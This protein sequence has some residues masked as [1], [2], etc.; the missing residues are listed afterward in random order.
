MP[1]TDTPVAAASQPTVPSSSR[2]DPK[3]LWLLAALL[4]L[5]RI[6][7]QVMESRRPIAEVA[8]EAEDVVRWRTPEQG[9]VEA[10][11]LRKPML[12]DF[13]AEWCPPCQRM[14][15]ELF[16]DPRSAQALEQMVV[17]IRVVDREREEGRNP[18]VT[19]SLQRAYRVG[20]FPTL[21]VAWPDREGYE[22]SSGYPGVEATLQWVGQSAMKVRPGLSDPLQH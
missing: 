11:A 20:A 14:K 12:Y 1:P 2:R 7:T 22:T 9:V 10:R 3:W 19:D 5:A 4:L 17:P 16:A 18:A 8:T 15:A 6:A 21:I 13:T